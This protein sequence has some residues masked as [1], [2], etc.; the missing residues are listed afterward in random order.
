MELIRSSSSRGNKPFLQS[1]S[2]LVE[3]AVRAGS[4]PFLGLLLF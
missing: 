3:M 4:A 1:L 2:V